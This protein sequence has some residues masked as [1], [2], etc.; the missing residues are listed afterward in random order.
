MRTTQGRTLLEIEP[1]LHRI[2][3]ALDEDAA[4]LPV[5]QRTVDTNQPI[6]IVVNERFRFS[7]T[8]DATGRVLGRA[9]LQERNPPWQ[10]GMPEE[11]YSVF[12][13]PETGERLTWAEVEAALRAKGDGAS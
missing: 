7:Y 3:Q 11:R 8:H 9:S 2:Q 13:D 12:E 4:G 5:T 6:F 1:S 10:P